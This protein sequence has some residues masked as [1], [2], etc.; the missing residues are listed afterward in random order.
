MY[1]LETNVLCEQE[2]ICTEFQIAHCSD[3]GRCCSFRRTHEARMWIAIND[4]N[5]SH[6]VPEYK[7]WRFTFMTSMGMI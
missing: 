2:V 5:E 6:G 3:V 7:N 1:S 4:W